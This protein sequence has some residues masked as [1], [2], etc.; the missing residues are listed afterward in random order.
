MKKININ[1]YSCAYHCDTCEDDH[2][3]IK[4]QVIVDGVERFYLKN[5]NN[6]GLDHENNFLLNEYEP[7]INKAYHF[8]YN[9]LTKSNAEYLSYIEYLSKL[10]HYCESKNI[11][12]ET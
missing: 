10:M 1:D 7:T 8:I 3:D 2:L 9:E 11:K 5:S 6:P 4:I 12:I